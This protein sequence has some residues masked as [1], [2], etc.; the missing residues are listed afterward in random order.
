MSLVWKT[1][2]TAA[3]ALSLR[4]RHLSYFTRS[5]LKTCDG[6]RKYTANSSTRKWYLTSLASKNFVSFV[7]Y[8]LNTFFAILSSAHSK[9]LFA[10]RHK[11]VSDAS[12]TYLNETGKSN[13]TSSS[14]KNTLFNQFLSYPSA[15]ASGKYEP[16]FSHQTLLISDWKVSQSFVSLNDC[17]FLL[18]RRSL[19][20]FAPTMP[21]YWSVSS[22]RQKSSFGCL[23]S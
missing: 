9:C 22:H 13:V 15:M 23:E 4:F 5:I 6:N 7:S 12:F 14:K 10:R 20:F 1:P 8:I 2:C 11:I 16:F 18:G 3:S 17:L 21:P 19:R